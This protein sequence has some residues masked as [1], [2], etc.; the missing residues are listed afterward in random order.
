MDVV[1][2]AE[3]LLQP[4]ASFHDRLRSVDVGSYGLE[5]VPNPFGDDARLV[6]PLDVLHAHDLPEIHQEVSG[7]GFDLV[8]QRSCKSHVRLL[9][10]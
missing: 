9:C 10:E 4:L 7:M 2:V 8:C 5:E 6:Q 3:Q 1:Q